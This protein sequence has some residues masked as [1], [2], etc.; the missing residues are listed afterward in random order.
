[1]ANEISV[2]A[3]LIINDGAN[4][5]VSI[6]PGAVQA[7][8]SAKAA[9]AGVI[10]VGTAAEAVAMGD[11]ATAG[12]SH[13]KNL[14]TT[15]GEYVEIGGG[16]TSSFVPVVRLYPGEPGLFPLATTTVIVRASTSQTNSV[17]LQHHIQSR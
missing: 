10:T 3:A 16:S 4:Y 13:W 12:W 2:T 14:S 11:V 9:A 8:M 6:Q 7:D 5:K 17:S 15:S 1:M